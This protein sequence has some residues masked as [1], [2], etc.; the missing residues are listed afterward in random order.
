MPAF[1]SKMNNPS[2]QDDPQPDEPENSANELSPSMVKLPWL[3]SKSIGSGLFLAVMSSAVISLGGVAVLFYQVL[4]KQAEIQIRDRLSTEVN[5]IESELTPVQQSLR[6]LGSSMV[7]LKQQNIQVPEQYETI[8]LDFFVERPSLVMGASLQQTPYAI[9]SDRQWYA[10]YYYVS[11]GQPDQIGETLPAPHNNITHADLV[12]EDN[13]PNQD[14]YKLT[15]AAGKDTWL[16]PYEWYG[17]TMSTLNHLLFNRQNQLAGFVSMDVNLTALSEAI[18]SSVIHNTG[19]FV[20]VTEQGNLVSYPPDPT[21]VRQSYQT[22]PELTTVWQQLQSNSSGLLTSGGQYWAYQR[23]PSTHWLMLAVVPKSVILLPVLTI[24]VG[25]TLGV[26]VVLAIVVSLFVQ[27]LNHRLKPILDECQKLAEVDARRAHRSA[28]HKKGAKSSEQIQSLELQHADELDVLS[29][30]FHRMADQLKESFEQLELRVEERTLELK[31]AKEMADAA[32]KAKSDFLAN[33]SHELRT[34][35]NGILGYAQILQG[36]RSMTEKEKKGVSIIY[37][38]G[39][40]LLTLINDI[41]DL[42]KIEARKLELQPAGFHLPSFLQG[43]AEICRVK[44]E[45]KR[46]GFVYQPDES[47]PIGVQADDKRLRQVLINLLSNAIKFTDRGKVRFLVKVQK[48]GHEQTENSLFYR[49]RFQV[50]DTGIGMSSEQLERIFLPFEQ[51]GNAEKQSEGT[52]LGLAISQTIV[53]MMNSTIQVQ[54]QPSIGSTFWFDVDLESTEW[55]EK[56]RV[57]EQGTLIGFKG[58]PKTILIVDDRWENRSVV[59]NLLEPLGF[60]V[61]EASDGKDGLDK[62]FEH[63]PDLIITDITMPNMNG[64]EMLSTLRQSSQFQDIC[65]IVSS[66]SAFEADRQKSLDAGANEFLPKPVQAENLFEALRIHLNVEWIYETQNTE[67]QAATPSQNAAAAI[68]PPATEDLMLLYDLSRKGLIN[69][70][71]KEID[72][73]EHTNNTL[74]PFTQQLRQLAKTFQLK[75]IRTIL[76]QHLSQH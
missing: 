6:H 40:H 54:S 63:C 42:S 47:L 22:I 38:C 51:F 11:S 18:S 53:S 3:R 17:I 71:L 5:A 19:Y 10:P 2:D 68:I 12:K 60:K 65:I 46:I 1:E 13:S 30:S 62:A 61:V 50:E 69:H 55:A 39:S 45:Q 8:L 43:V 21:K 58:K 66:A 15:I 57:F 72:R 75:Q 28:P 49:L 74:I 27:R 59:V 14:Y 56:I 44:A 25:A 20:V 52:G 26:G 24:T 34:P 16:E 35:L 64:Y 67:E 73:L 4:Q 33:M 36:S 41:L 7:L 31:R 32:N 9:L 37:Q 29:Y 48:V 23:L 70:L 76:E